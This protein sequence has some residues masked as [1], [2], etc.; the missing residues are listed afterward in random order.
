MSIDAGRRDVY[1]DRQCPDSRRGPEYRQFEKDDFGGGSLIS[2]GS[3]IRMKQKAHSV[4]EP[5]APGGSVA[6]LM[7]LRSKPDLYRITDQSET[8]IILRKLAEFGVRGLVTAFR[9]LE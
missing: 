7:F 5:G 3:Q 8:R 4:L 6:R 1:V 9:S 2:N